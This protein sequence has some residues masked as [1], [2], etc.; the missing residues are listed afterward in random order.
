MYQ[1]RGEIKRCMNGLQ[2]ILFEFWNSK[3]VLFAYGP[4]RSPRLNLIRVMSAWKITATISRPIVLLVTFYT[5][6]YLSSLLAPTKLVPLSERIVLGLPLRQRNLLKAIIKESVLKSPPNSK[7]AARVVVR[8]FKRQPHLFSGPLSL[9]AFIGP[10]SLLRSKTCD[11]QGPAFVPFRPVSVSHE[12][13]ESGALINAAL[14]KGSLG[15]LLQRN[16]SLV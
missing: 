1:M 10:I 8:H 14:V 12:G 13:I 7:W 2:T 3:F 5:N 16:R 6:H 4:I 11:V 9:L 15:A